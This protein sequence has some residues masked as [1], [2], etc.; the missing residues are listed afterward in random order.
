[1]KKVI[2]FKKD[3][4]FKT[5]LSEITSISLEH[6]LNE[7]VDNVVSG[8]F[9]ITGEYKIIDSSS[10]IEPFSYNLP[11]EIEL[12]DKYILDNILVDIDDFF[13]EIINNNILSVNIEIAVDKLDERK[14]IEINNEPK[15][16][17]I[18][19]EDNIISHN[20]VI[21]SFGELEGESKMKENIQNKF[22]NT[23]QD[24][25]MEE[26]R[27]LFDNFDLTKETFATYKICIIKEGDTVESIIQKYSTTKEEIEKYNDLKE[28]K[29]G[30]K[31]IIPTIIDAKI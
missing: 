9:L 8:E 13:Y 28:L 20:I 22:D 1:M 14:P 21:D 19:D 27:S 15:N 6:T 26:T 24:L 29:L 25:E 10:N 23:L 16:I 2:P 31:L 18:N 11:F 5:N 30:D 17:V 4:V 7:T 3:I 12:D